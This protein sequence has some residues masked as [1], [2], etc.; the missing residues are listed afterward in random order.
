MDA[1]AKRIKEQIKN[2]P[3]KEKMANYWNY[4]KVHFFVTIICIFIFGVSIVQCA[5]RV[6]SDMTVSIYSS[7]YIPEESVVQ[8]TELLNQ[9]CKDINGDDIVNVE[10]STNVADITSEKMDEMTQGVFAKLQAEL[11][12]NVAAG[13]IMDEA[14]KTMMVENYQYPEEDVIEISRVPEVAECM[15][16]T[17]EQ[18]LYWLPGFAEREKKEVSQFDNGKLTEDYFRNVIRKPDEKIGK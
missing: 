13:Y 5:T 18:T 8:L 7:V 1:E 6:K 3:F 11:G 15:N 12:A 9:K 10:I 16:L 4:Y 17:E 14:Y 2:L